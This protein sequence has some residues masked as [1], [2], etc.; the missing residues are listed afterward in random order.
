MSGSLSFVCDYDLI[1][2]DC[3]MPFIDGYETCKQIINNLR[4]KG[5]S[6]EMMP[7]IVAITGHVETEY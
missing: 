7:K 6:E 5:I 3:S 1:L 4:D 2:T